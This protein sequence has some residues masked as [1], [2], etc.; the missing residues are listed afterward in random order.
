[1]KSSR[2]EYVAAESVEHA[3]E[4]L[5]SLGGDA[6]LIAGGQSLVPM[7]AM[8]LA[9]PALLVDINRLEPLRKHALQADNVI[10]GA[11][12]TQASLERNDA[13]LD[14][15]PLV[16]LAM[17]WVGHQQTRNRG[18]VG[19]SLMQADPSAELPLIAV[20]LDAQLHVLGGGGQSREVSGAAFYQGVL[21][22]SVKETE[23]LAEID[24]PVWRANDTERVGAGFNEV[25]IR[26]GDFAIASAACQLTIN[27]D[28]VVT[29]A[30]MGLGGVDAVPLSV[31]DAVAS[32]VGQQPGDE[33][34]DHVSSMAAKVS[35][36]SSDIHA[37]AQYRRHL[38]EVLMRGVIRDALASAKGQ[39][40]HE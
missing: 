17:P 2:F 38:A 20:V 14:E 33:L 6:R 12:L 23:M 1:M 7:M 34:I 16:R 19:G 3:L 15:L 25:A 13:L 32:L 24:W 37:S 39:A 11:T 40:E 27:S 21:Q 36:P 8:R 4:L 10:T 5:A 18:T 35:E 29:R 22:T 26:S 28:G 30:A 9:S 31:P